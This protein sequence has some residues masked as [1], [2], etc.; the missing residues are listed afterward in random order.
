MSKKKGT[1]P[2]HMGNLLLVH[3]YTALD[4]PEH[5]YDYE[6]EF[7]T[8]TTC[9]D[10]YSLQRLDLGYNTCLDCG[11]FAAKQVKRCVAPINKSN[12]MLITNYEELAQLNPKRTA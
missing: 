2:N 6:E 8:C 3:D 10:D 11:E 4:T 1:W 12:Y 5:I 7:A 9:G